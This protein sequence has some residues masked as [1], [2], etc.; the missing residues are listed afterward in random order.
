MNRFDRNPNRDQLKTAT[1]SIGRKEIGNETLAREHQIKPV[2]TRNP[3]DILI[4]L[5]SIFN[6][7][8][9]D[10]SLF[11]LKKIS[12]SFYCSSCKSI[13][14]QCNVYLKKKREITT[15]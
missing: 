3:F 8:R 1:K 7:G 2:H 6:R 13:I 11:F 4:T 9:F 14:V 10:S 12:L 5:F 15:E